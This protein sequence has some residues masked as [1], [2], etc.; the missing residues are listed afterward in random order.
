MSLIRILFITVKN[1]FLIFFIQVYHQHFKY[2]MIIVVAGV[3]IVVISI[4]DWPLVLHVRLT[5]F[6]A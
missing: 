5:F 1:D 6:Y 2:I 3:R 4:C